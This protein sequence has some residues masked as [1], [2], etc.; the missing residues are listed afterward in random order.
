MGCHYY[1][2][3]VGNLFIRKFLRFL[4]A[5]NRSLCSGHFRFFVGY[6]VF[7]RLFEGLND[8]GNADRCHGHDRQVDDHLLDQGQE[9][10]HVRRGADDRGGHEGQ[11]EADDAPGQES[12]QFCGNRNPKGRSV[13]LA[14]MQWGDPE[15]MTRSEPQGV[16]DRPKE[17][18]V[19]DATEFP[20]TQPN[21]VGR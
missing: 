6:R 1:F 21:P 4:N 10:D 17:N 16:I 13:C 18:Y 20:V 12:K 11:T 9:G 14:H 5:L 3:I 19:T 15:A 7:C 8:R 2:G